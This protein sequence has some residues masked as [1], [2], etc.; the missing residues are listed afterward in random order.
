MLIV[1]IDFSYF[2]SPVKLLIWSMKLHA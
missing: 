1:K 2:L